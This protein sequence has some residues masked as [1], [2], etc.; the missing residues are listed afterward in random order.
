MFSLRG[1]DVWPGM[2]AFLFLSNAGLLLFFPPALPA[3]S[4]LGRGYAPRACGFDL[5]DDF[6]YGEPAGDCNVCDGTTLDPDGDGV[7]EDLIYVD[8]DN[9]PAGGDGSSASPFR[10]LQTAFDAI[11]GPGDGA[12]DIICFRGTCSPERIVLTTSGIATTKLRPRA[13]TEARDFQY[14]ADPAMLVGWDTDNDGI[15]P[16]LDPDDTAV[17]D[18]AQLSMPFTLD[19]G[20]SVGYIELAHFSVRDYGRSDVN[21]GFLDLGGHGGTSTHIFVHDV[22]LDSIMKDRSLSGDT[23]LFP[24][25]ATGKAL[26][27]VAVENVECIDCGGYLMRGDGGDFVSTESGPVRVKNFTHLA[28]ACDWSDCSSGAAVLMFKMWGYYQGIEIL[29][30]VFDANVGDWE[31]K[32]SGGPHGALAFVPAQ[33]SRDWTIRGN[34]IIDYKLAVIV[35]PSASSACNEPGVARTLKDVVFDRNIIRNTYDPWR[36][37]DMGIHIRKGDSTTRTLENVTITNNFFSSTTGWETCIWS[38]AGNPQGNQPGVV[39]IVNN[40]CHGTINRHAAFVLG[41]AEGAEQN[42]PLQSYVIKNNLISGLDSGDLA[43]STEFSVQD[44]AS[45][46]NVFPPGALFRWSGGT[47]TDLGTWRGL[48]GGDASSRTCT[49]AYENAL[50]GD[51]HLTLLDSCARDQGQSL[52]AITTVDVDGDPRGDGPVWDIGADET[53]FIFTDGFESGDL[54]RWSASH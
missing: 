23:I 11:T 32:P 16:P 6:L 13:G 51:F 39:E 27:H 18:G 36:F 45:D 40:T 22:S 12:E 15:Y 46:T 53:R 33:C 43:L 10:T 47:K 8:C 17:L 1:I 35:Q 4:T 31:P 34:E 28:H 49:P 52:P 19:R 54:T 21:S 25:F 2:G 48:S 42:F 5:N 26:R 20:A 44:L 7:N 9:A 3:Q 37:G 30:S 24:A 41:N 38:A 50:S 14:P 29:D